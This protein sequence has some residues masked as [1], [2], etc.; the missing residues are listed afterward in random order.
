[1]YRDSK[2]LGKRGRHR[3]VPTF[4]IGLTQAFKHRFGGKVVRIKVRQV[5]GQTI[6]CP[7]AVYVERLNLVLRDGLNCLSRKT[8][9]KAT[10]VNQKGGQF[11]LLGSQATSPTCRWDIGPK[12]RFFPFQSL[13]RCAQLLCPRS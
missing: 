13:A 9:E 10:T 12:L 8:Q 1:M 7:Y 3:L 11:R 6:D 4:G 2:R 5:L